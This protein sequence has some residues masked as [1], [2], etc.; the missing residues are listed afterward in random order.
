MYETCF[1]GYDEIGRRVMRL[2]DCEDDIRTNEAG[3]FVY[4]DSEGEE[5][6]LSAFGVVVEH[7]VQD[8]EKKM[9]Q[10]AG[11]SK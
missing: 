6:H 10:K 9:N 7:I 11:V 2:L 4:T 5:M 3:N 1:D 8:V